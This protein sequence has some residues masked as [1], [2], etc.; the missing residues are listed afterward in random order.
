MSA[1]IASSRTGQQ[2]RWLRFF[3]YTVAVLLPVGGMEFRFPV[4]NRRF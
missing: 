3:G 4:L 2:G 1:T